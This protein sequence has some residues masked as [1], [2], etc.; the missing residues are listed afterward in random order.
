MEQEIL[1]WVKLIPSKTKE[2]SFMINR[3]FGIICQTVTD[4]YDYTIYRHSNGNTYIIDD[5]VYDNPEITINQALE[6]LLEE[7]FVPT[8]NKGEITLTN[9]TYTKRFLDSLKKQFS[10]Y[11]QTV[12]QSSA[13]SISIRIGTRTIVECIKID[14]GYRY[15]ISIEVSKTPITINHNLVAIVADGVCGTTDI[16]FADAF[17]LVFDTVPV[18]S[19]IKTNRPM[20]EIVNQIND[21]ANDLELS[22]F[23]DD[24]KYVETPF[25]YLDDQCGVYVDNSS[26]KSVIKIHYE[27]PDDKSGFIT[28]VNDEEFGELLETTFHIGKMKAVDIADMNS[29][30]IEGKLLL[31]AVAGALIQHLIESNADLPKAF[32]GGTFWITTTELKGRIQYANL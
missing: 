3:E 29:I 16:T 20:Y 5:G 19:D 10:D 11:L 8:K 9:Y 18:F 12:T 2:I 13:K 21:L 17:Q 27:I 6:E 32:A 30:S 31:S 23:N 24:T 7:S 22:G 4:G 1:S 28:W 26:T 15:I 25:L 14:T